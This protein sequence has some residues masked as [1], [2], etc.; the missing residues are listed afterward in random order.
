MD[1]LKCPACTEETRA[2]RAS[3]YVK[4]EDCKTIFATRDISE[5][6]ETENDNPESRNTAQLHETR[7]RRLGDV[8]SVLDF[9]CGNGEF[10]DYLCHH[11]VSCQGYDQ[12]YPWPGFEKF[13]AITMIEVIEHL[14][15]PREQL[16]ACAQLLIDG[17]KIY[18]ESTFSDQIKDFTS[19]PYVDPRIG[20]VT[21]LSR[22]GLRRI[23][24]EGFEAN[25]INPNV[26]LLRKEN[27]SSAG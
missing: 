9:G 24:P 19:H 2:E 13:D 10:L 25:W 27:P 5:L 1:F 11:N 3:L 23:L 7:L 26:V 15:D 22:E 21:I 20:H 6:I 4:C 17:G 14:R 18:I 12:G 8:T 16:R